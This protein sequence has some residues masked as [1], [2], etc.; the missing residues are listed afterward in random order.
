MKGEVIELSLKDLCTEFWDDIVYL[1]DDRILGNITPL[2][3]GMNHLEI[4]KL[5]FDLDAGFMKK[6]SLY[7][8]LDMGEAKREL[9]MAA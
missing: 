6:L 8:H 7:L 5:Y 9:M 2:V 3:E 1:M 4:L